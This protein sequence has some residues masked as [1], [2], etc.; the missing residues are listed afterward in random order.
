M[1]YQKFCEETDELY[2]YC[3]DYA[4]D[5]DGITN[6]N[7]NLLKKINNAGYELKII[8]INFN[9]NKKILKKKL[10]N[11]HLSYK[12]TNKYIFI[13]WNFKLKE[14]KYLKNDEN[15]GDRLRK[16]SYNNKS[17]FLNNS[18]WLPN[19]L[20]LDYHENILKIIFEKIEKNRY[21]YDGIYFKLFNQLID[22]N[23]LL[24]DEHN[25]LYIKDYIIIEGIDDIIFEKLLNKYF[26]KYK[27]LSEKNTLSENLFF[28]K[29]FEIIYVYDLIIEFV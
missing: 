17:R 6:F 10:F 25:K 29:P 8:D 16:I 18:R 1:N 24:Y 21:Y 9:I 26:K 15:F 5:Y 22:Q 3:L 2:Q 13:T 11:D 12:I 4:Y 23:E 28:S 27:F 20:L 14:K 7:G 19:N